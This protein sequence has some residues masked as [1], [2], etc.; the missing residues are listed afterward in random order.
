MGDDYGG[1]GVELRDTNGNTTAV[2]IP[3]TRSQ[4]SGRSG[5]IC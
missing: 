4:K 3:V 1:N 2:A 5:G